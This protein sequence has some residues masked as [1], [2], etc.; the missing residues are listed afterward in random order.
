[1]SRIE[2][3]ALGKLREKFE[4]GESAEESEKYENGIESVEPQEASLVLSFLFDK[5]A[6]M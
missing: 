5:H 3:K 1:M 4:L 6:S 2:K